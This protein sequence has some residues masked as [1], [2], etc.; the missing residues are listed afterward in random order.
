[1]MSPAQTSVVLPE[2]APRLPLS[3]SVRTFVCLRDYDFTADMALLRKKAAEH[4]REFGQADPES[5]P[6]DSRHTCW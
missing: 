4:L 3:D 6:L 2:I 5:I 1:M